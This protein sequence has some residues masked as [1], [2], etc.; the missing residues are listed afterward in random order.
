[1]I[2][3]TINNHCWKII[4]QSSEELKKT[5]KEKENDDCR[6]IYGYTDYTQQN[7]FLNKD[8]CTSQKIRTLKHELTHCYIW[9]QGLYNVVNVNEETICDLVACSNDFIN[10]VVNL[11]CDYKDIKN[12]V[13]IG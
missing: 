13:D 1:M 12:N 2:D 4:E 9:E 3:F 11:F 8:L 10:K 5:Y 6:F 7:I